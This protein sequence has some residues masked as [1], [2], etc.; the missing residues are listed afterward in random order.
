MTGSYVDV[1][2]LDFL[3]SNLAP[4]VRMSGTVDHICAIA[5]PFGGFTVSRF[6]TDLNDY[7]SQA[8]DTV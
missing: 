1:P 5:V 8:L 4:L 2:L 6:G 7:G 3:L